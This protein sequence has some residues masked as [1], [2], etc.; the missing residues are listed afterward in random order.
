MYALAALNLICPLVMLL[1]GY[2]LKKHPAK[3]MSRNNGYNTAMARKSQEHWNYAQ[4]I[5]P[6]IFI[7]IGIAISVVELMLSAVLYIQKVSVGYVVLI[8]TVVGFAALIYGFLKTDKKIE[9]HFSR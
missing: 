3:E 9:N 7:G 8:G 4:N 2:I 5:A 6:D 1:V